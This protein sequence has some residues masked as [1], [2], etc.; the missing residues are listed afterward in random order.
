MKYITQFEQST[1][2]TFQFPLDSK[3]EFDRHIAE[4]TKQGYMI[5]SGKE[6]IDT[7]EGECMLSAIDF[8]PTGVD[9][10]IEGY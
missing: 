8:G 7:I 5:L 9:T 3:E 1:G 10:I 6:L 4:F 2:L